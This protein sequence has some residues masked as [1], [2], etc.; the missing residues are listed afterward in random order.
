[1]STGLRTAPLSRF[2]PHGWRVGLPLTVILLIV[3]GAVAVLLMSARFEGERRGEQLIS[4]TL[5]AEQAITFEIER[6]IESMQILAHDVDAGGNSPNAYARRAAELL[7][8]SSEARMLCR[9]DANLALQECFPALLHGDKGQRLEDPSAWHETVELTVRL[10]RPVATLWTTGSQPWTAILAVPA[11]GN[12]R[13]RA[14]VAVVS[15]QRLLDN[16]L[17]WWF[18]H[19]NEVTLTD[20]D[21]NVLA[22]RDPNV[23]GRGVYTHRIATS[24]AGLTLY[25]NA[26]STRGHPHLVPDILAGAVI[27]LSGLLAWSIWQLWRDLV[28]RSRA[29]HALREQQAL[30]HAME[31]SLMSGLRARDLD[32]RITYVNH[33]FCE[34]V[35]YRADELIG[36]APPMP[37]W[38][39]EFTGRSLSR[40]AQLLART[41]SHDAHES[42]YLRRDGTRLTVLVSEAPLLDGN[43]KQTGWMA[44]I[45][46]ITEQKRIQEFQRSQNERMNHMSR[47]M[48]MGEMASALAHELNQ[49]LA[50]VNS[51]CT[52]ALN[53]MTSG[54]APTADTSGPHDLVV[55]ARTQVERAGQI[56]RRVHHFVRKT[57][58]SSG[59]LEL[60]KV[61]AELLPLVQLQTSR[62]GEQIQTEMAPSLPPVLADRVLLE[63][64]L[65][66]LTRNAFDAMAHLPVTSRR[67]LISAESI[68]ARECAAATVRVSVRDWG[69]GLDDSVREALGAPFFTTRR[70][71]MG[72]GLAVCRSALEMMNSHLKF[73]AAE[74]AGARFYFDLLT[75][76]ASCETSI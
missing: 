68:C 25:L 62:S 9:I 60:P 45:M 24:L 59:L 74:G 13:Y 50:A 14:L 66:N 55:K 39:P 21:G 11:P 1:M 37:Y 70:D 12:E 44:S 58:V 36:C 47:L 35:G 4:D 49:P 43:G 40:H 72:M 69:Q 17:P 7:Q 31:N 29:E 42:V 76:E 61:I 56:I 22:V 75:G 67:V 33:A 57:D 15:I 54:N 48:T 28:R 19:D 2:K 20:L 8:R 6:L 41:L 34:M 18:A 16:T 73:E 52:A 5:W 26:N 38:A 46:D 32:G 27:A 51:Y 23:K 10:G 53:L 3:A 65:L 63:Q 64:V 71:G 30:R